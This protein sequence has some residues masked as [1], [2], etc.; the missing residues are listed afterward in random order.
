MGS[1][2]FALAALWTLE[3]KQKRI[4]RKLSKREHAL[5][6]SVARQY[7]KT[8]RHME[9]PMF[10][11]FGGIHHMFSLADRDQDGQVSKEEFLLFAEALLRDFVSEYSGAI[12]AGLPG[13]VISID[14]I[15]QVAL[16]Q[17]KRFDWDKSGKLDQDE[18]HAWAE[19]FLGSATASLVYEETQGG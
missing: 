7:L 14:K 11:S 17:F 18:F 4:K 16:E 9:I 1:A 2:V 8:R 19:S 12:A 5:V 6:R 3:K 10:G 15:R 13:G